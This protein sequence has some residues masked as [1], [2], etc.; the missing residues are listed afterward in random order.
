M[1]PQ[2]SNKSTRR[3]SASRT[4][5]GQNRQQADQKPRSNSGTRQDL[6]AESA[7]PRMHLGKSELQL[8]KAAN[9]ERVNH[10][11]ASSLKSSRR[12]Q[13]RSNLG[14]FKAESEKLRGVANQSNRSNRG[15]SR[16]SE[17]QSTSNLRQAFH[18][19]SFA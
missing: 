6:L 5:S 7:G 4:G 12:K 9:V 8:S 19:S 3:E 10:L 16:E 18:T 15:Q 1:I 2:S 13:I 11:E 17:L 14:S